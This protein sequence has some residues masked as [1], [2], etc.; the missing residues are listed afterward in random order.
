MPSPRRLA[1]TVL[2][3]GVVSRGWYSILTGV[4]ML[5]VAWL[6][7]GVGD[8]DPA[9]APVGLVLAVVGVWCLARG[10]RLE[11]RRRAGD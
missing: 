9:A 10:V 3:K 2:S 5:Y 11:A 8:D 7:S 1:A 6:L 4:A